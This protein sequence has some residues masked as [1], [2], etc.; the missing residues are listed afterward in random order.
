MSHRCATQAKTTVPAMTTSKRGTAVVIQNPDGSLVRER[1]RPQ[2]P[3]YAKQTYY[4]EL[5][6]HALDDDTSLIETLFAYAIDFLDA[7]H[8]EVRVAD[9]E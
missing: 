5:P 3:R 6:H 2:L 4:A 9:P 1:N 8:V 7:R